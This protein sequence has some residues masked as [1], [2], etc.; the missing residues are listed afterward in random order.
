VSLAH[1]LIVPTYNRPSLL[2]ALICHLE[3][4]G[5]FLN[6]VVAD[7]STDPDR[8]R[9][10]EFL[11]ECGS[12]VRHLEFPSDISFVVKLNIVLREVRTKYVS[13]CADDDMVFV[14]AVESCIDELDR[15]PELVGCHGT[16]LN[17][18]F[19]ES[20]RAI[21]VQVEY[22]SPSIEGDAF[23]ARAWQLLGKYEALFYGVYRTEVFAS[24]L[25]ACEK[26]ASSD[27]WEYYFWEL[28]SAI[29][30]LA[31]GK[32]RRIDQ[33]YL[34]RRSFPPQ[35]PTRWHP[36]VLVVDDPDRFISE[37]M[38]YR[39]RLMLYLAAIGVETNGEFLKHLTLAHLI[40][41][42]EEGG[43]GVGIKEMIQRKLREVSGVRSIE[44]S[45]LGK[46][47]TRSMVRWLSH[48]IKRSRTWAKIRRRVRGPAF[49][50][51]RPNLYADSV[52]SKAISE[53][54]AMYGRRVF[55]VP[56]GGKSGT[57]A[58]WRLDS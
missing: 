6:I 41:F 2:R 22:S 38:H 12:H 32:M 35:Q 33:V 50:D 27:Y 4:E 40:Y 30:V 43:S 14:D 53:Q 36:A 10:R 28:F 55:D 44:A 1:T 58:T 23:E 24:V 31:H 56:D 8:L 3:S 46:G 20:D 13:V 18:K 51:V 26:E 15:D 19:A 21:D 47:R 54:L 49:V 16:Y 42:I 5:R 45:A 29:A 9:N 25:K 34:A 37:F 52:M 57:P 39:E 11:K 7:S 48:R 17:F